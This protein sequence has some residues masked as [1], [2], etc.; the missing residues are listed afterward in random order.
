[1]FLALFSQNCFY[2]RRAYFVLF[3][4]FNY[5]DSFE[6]KWLLLL[7]KKLMKNCSFFETREFTTLVSII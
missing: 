7:K 2:L 3:S 1:M 5:I 4:V 6:S